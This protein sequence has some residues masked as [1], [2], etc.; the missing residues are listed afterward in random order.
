MDHSGIFRK[1]HVGEYGQGGKQGEKAQEQ[2][3]H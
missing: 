2:H 3:H 1:M